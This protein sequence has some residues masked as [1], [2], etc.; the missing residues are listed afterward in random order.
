MISA[1]EGLQGF[2]SFGS[3]GSQVQF[4]VFQVQEK[5]QGELKKIKE[6][7]SENTEEIE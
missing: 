6:H 5:I 3:H 2:Q 4:N 1:S 7:E